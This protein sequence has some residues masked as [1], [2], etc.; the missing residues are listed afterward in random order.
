MVS[1]YMVFPFADKRDSK[2]QSAEH[3]SLTIGIKRL[4]CR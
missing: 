1:E 3:T 2:T 4:E